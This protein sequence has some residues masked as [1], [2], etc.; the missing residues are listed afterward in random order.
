MKQKYADTQQIHHLT[1][2]Y[3]YAIILPRIDESFGRLK[4]LR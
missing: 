2:V 1:R 3:N 4:S